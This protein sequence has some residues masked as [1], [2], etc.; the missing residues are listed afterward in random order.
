MNALL[1]LTA[2]V[3][4]RS[5]YFLALICMSAKLR[6]PGIVGYVV[7]SQEVSGLSLQKEVMH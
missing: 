5:N 7:Y 1:V 4:V 6:D 2:C 3:Y